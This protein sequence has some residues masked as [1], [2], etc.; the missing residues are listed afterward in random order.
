V[1]WGGQFQA[2][3]M[4]SW[5]TPA[6][7]DANLS[8]E[9]DSWGGDY[10]ALTTRIER[11]R[12][13]WDVVH[14]EAHYVMTP[15]FQQLFRSYPGRS[16]ATLSPAISGD[17]VLRDL[18]AQGRAAPV[19]EYAYVVAGRSDRLGGRRAADITWQ[20]FWNISAI[21]GRRGLRN[22]PVGN[23]EAALASLGKDPQTY[24]YEERDPVR[25]RQKVTEAL[26]RLAQIRPQI[27][28]WESGDELQQQLETG[29]VALVGAWSGRV[30][31]AFRTLCP[32]AT[33]IADCTVGANP[34]TALIST[35]WWIIPNGAPHPDNGNRLLQALFAQT[36]VGGAARFAT[37]QGYS[38]PVRGAV[39][40]DPVARH[41][42]QL[43]S[44]ENPQRLARI[45]E[46]FWGEHFDEI[47]QM[48]NDWRAR[49]Q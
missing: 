32:H 33:A 39:I 12:N 7:R 9:S 48:W 30:R 22:F 17:E 19:L 20:D 4:S 2:D 8:L 47:N 36:Q 45:N 6:A 10:G 24:L 1:S 27:V 37:Q 25:L 23:I 28:W 21:P 13:N 42:L 3:L 15:R 18:I 49:S 43:G 44:S 40:Q 35:D 26:E 29:D 14:V 41:F 31:A 34:A 46:R 5:V 11:Q 16:L 38:V